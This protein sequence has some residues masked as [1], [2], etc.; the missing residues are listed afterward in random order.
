MRHGLIANQLD[1]CLN[2]RFNARD[3]CWW[4]IKAIDDYI[5]FTSDYSILDISVKM[6]FL[7]DN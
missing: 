5:N 1:K 4:F 3:V 7:S 2:A 6:Q